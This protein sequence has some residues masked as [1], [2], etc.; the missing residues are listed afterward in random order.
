MSAIQ[1][2]GYSDLLRR[3]LGMKGQSDV[4]GDLSPEISPILCLELPRP[5]WEFLKGYR[6]CGC[7]LQAGSA[8]AAGPTLRIRNPAGSGMIAT[9]DW[10]EIGVSTIQDTVAVR[11]NLLDADLATGAVLLTVRETR[12]LDT[13]GQ[14]QSALTGS[15]SDAAGPV[16]DEI[17]VQTIALDRIRV[18]KGP[19]VL[20][21]GR[22][23]DI[24]CKVVQVQV[25]RFNVTWSE[26]PLPDLER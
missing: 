18:Y 3:F 4:A 5:D 2:G 26:R 1:R 22:S 12:L 6:L 25:A 17:Y 10:I 14:N 13:L 16:G 7:A 19:V 11:V 20:T 21:P 9:L 24:G 15:F 8:A 23:V